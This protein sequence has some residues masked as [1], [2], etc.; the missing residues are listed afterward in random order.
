MVKG[1]IKGIQ[2]ERGEV[3]IGDNC[4]MAILKLMT[5]GNLAES[6]AD[7]KIPRRGKCPMAVADEN[8]GKPNWRR[9]GRLV[10]NAEIYSSA[11]RAFVILGAARR[12]RGN[13]LQ[14]N[15]IERMKHMEA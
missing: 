1:G 12:S 5:I 2:I 9:Y 8:R 4:P 10:V 11:I 7:V 15:G 13:R 3:R 14:I 6:A